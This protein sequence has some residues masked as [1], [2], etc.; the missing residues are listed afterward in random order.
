MFYAFTCAST[1]NSQFWSCADE[2]LSK[3]LDWR[4]VAFE[5]GR[6]LH[7]IIWDYLH[8]NSFRWY[9]ASCPS[10]DETMICLW[11][12]NPNCFL[13]DVGLTF[14]AIHQITGCRCL[15]AP[16]VL[17][18]ETILVPKLASTRKKRGGKWVEEYSFSLSKFKE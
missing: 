13:G 1:Q 14:R 11:E 16:D 4:L 7:P 17:M 10:L 15:F 9:D 8:G 12:L 3:E 6:N 5:T 18:T 2:K